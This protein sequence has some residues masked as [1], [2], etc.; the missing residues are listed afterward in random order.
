MENA[1][2]LAKT[3]ISGDKISAGKYF[4]GKNFGEHFRRNFFPPKF[5]LLM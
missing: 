5:L 4:G 1:N 2:K 3:K